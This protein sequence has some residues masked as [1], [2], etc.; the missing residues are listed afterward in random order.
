MLHT[1]ILENWAAFKSLTIICAH[2]Q[3]RVLYNKIF[4]YTNSYE[5]NA[6]KQWKMRII[7]QKI[8]SYK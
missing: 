8:M 5:D 1:Y 2:L 6:V 7:P 3:L 4:L